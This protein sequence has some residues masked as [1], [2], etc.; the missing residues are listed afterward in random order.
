MRTKPHR[1]ES[2]SQRD[3]RLAPREASNGHST[4]GL[5][6]PF[7]ARENVERMLEEH[8][9]RALRF[10]RELAGNHHDADDLFHQAALVA[11]ARPFM[12]PET[13]TWSWLSNLIR[14]CHRNAVAKNLRRDHI[15]ATANGTLSR[16]GVA[17]AAEEPLMRAELLEAIAQ[18]M[19]QIDEADRK[20]LIGA[21]VENRSHDELA[22]SLGVRRTAVTM[23]LTRLISKLRVQAR[24]RRVRDLVG[25][26]LAAILGKHAVAKAAAL[27]LVGG[28]V[29]SLAVGY[30]SNSDL[31]P[32]TPT[33]STH[34]E[35]PRRL[36]SDASGLTYI[37]TQ[38]AYRSSGR[39]WWIEEAAEEQAGALAAG[40]PIRRRI[41]V[42]DEDGEALRVIEVWLK[43]GT[44]TVETLWQRDLATEAGKHPPPPAWTRVKV[45]ALDRPL[46]TLLDGVRVLGRVDVQRRGT[47]A[48]T[49]A[50][51]ADAAELEA[52]GYRPLPGASDKPPVVPLPAYVFFA[53]DR[54]DSRPWYKT[55]G[56]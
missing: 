23:R 7:Q 1:L 48:I 50:W 13:A 43:D 45:T 46:P 36:T 37:R 20:L 2:D 55:A 17:P 28:T 8:R 56:R 30:A 27:L 31:S 14:T 15:T 34:D 10:A 6:S 26:I 41:E 51:I 35:A 40:A 32:D 16:A 25:A 44:E 53:R 21:V 42:S 19:S 38:V 33:I 47:N 39:C 5:R 24:W 18:E 4:L 49:R 29:A 22:E 12:V 54:F 9:E 52:H 3:A 11:L